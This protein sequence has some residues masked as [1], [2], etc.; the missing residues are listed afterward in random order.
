MLEEFLNKDR[1]LYVFA[2]FKLLRL[3]D[4]DSNITDGDVA[5]IFYN[6]FLNRH[7]TLVNNLQGFILDSKNYDPHKYRDYTSITI[8]D[9]ESENILTLMNMGMDFKDIIYIRHI[10]RKEDT[11]KW[12]SYET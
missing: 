1:E 3:L 4:A 11:L 7:S 5:C 2:P 12:K 8:D 10:N 9:E 6:E